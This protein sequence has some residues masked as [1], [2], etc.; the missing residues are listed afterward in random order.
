MKSMDGHGVRNPNNA[1]NNVVKNLKNIVGK[2]TTAMK[3]PTCA[4]T[5]PLLT[6]NILMNA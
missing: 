4:V 1:K 2:I 3:T 6:A 5:P